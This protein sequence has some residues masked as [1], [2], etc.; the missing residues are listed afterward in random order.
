MGDTERRPGVPGE[1]DSTRDDALDTGVPE[2]VGPI[3]MTTLAFPGNDFRGEILPELDKLKKAVSFGSYVGAL[4]GYAAAGAAGIEKGAMAGA[5]ELADGHLFDQDDVFRVT[6]ALPNDM[7]AVLVLF[8]H[9]WA[10]SLLEA[11][12]R[13]GGIE[14]TNDWVRPEEAVSVVHRAVP[15]TTA[16]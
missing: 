16:S 8:E 6:Q 13:A 12:D 11:V 9:L 2:S 10:K 14:L 4:A 5:A 7:S 3:Q 1:D 15:P